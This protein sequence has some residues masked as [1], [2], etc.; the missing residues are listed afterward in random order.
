M[1]T[2]YPALT[3]KQMIGLAAKEFGVAPK[4][5]ILSKGYIRFGGIFDQLVKEL[6]E[7][8]YQNESEYIFDSSKYEKAFGIAPTSYEEGVRQ[9]VL[10][11]KK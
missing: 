8:L 6:Y 7:M 5:S 1:P 3:G 4:F 10:S 9:T 2:A 11:Y